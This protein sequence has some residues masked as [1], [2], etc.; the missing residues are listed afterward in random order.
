MKAWGTTVVL[1]AVVAAFALTARAG[2]EP[3]WIDLE[4]CSMCKHL[5]GEPGL[6]EHLSWESFSIS[7]GMMMV[8]TVEPEYEKAY[9]KAGMNMQK[10][11]AELQAGAQMPLCGTCMAWGGLLM[12][13]A[14]MDHLTTKAGHVTLLTGTEPELVAKIQAFAKR[15]QE[16]MEKHEA[17]KKKG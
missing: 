1:L 16:E 15:N 10:T 4:N 3:A 8:T 9:A 2:E 6:M 5:T 17:A 13:G 11:G 12:S 14:K 7:T